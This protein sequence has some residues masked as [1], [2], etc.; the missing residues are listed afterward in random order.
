MNKYNS[1]CFECIMVTDV[2][3]LWISMQ[4]LK[5]MWVIS[6]KLVS[7]LTRIFMMTSLY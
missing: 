5:D 7:S 3:I 2:S 6:E 4:V 1:L